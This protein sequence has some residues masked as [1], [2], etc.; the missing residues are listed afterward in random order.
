MYP[1]AVLFLW[2]CQADPAAP[3]APPLDLVLVTLDT[4]R[5]DRLGA[6]GD[7]LAKTPNLDGLAAR[8]ALFREAYTPVPLTLPA[9]ASLLTGLYPDR[10]GLRDNSGY[11][12]G[13]AVVTVTERLGAEGYHTGAFVGAYVLDAAWGLDAGFD[14]YQG[15]FHPEDVANATDPGDVQRPAREV[16][17]EALAWWTSTASPRFLWV[18]L[19]D[20]HAPYAP[21]VDW[22]GD[23]YRGEVFEV[24]RALRSLLQTVGTA[25]LV[26]VAGDH[27]ENLGDGGEL[28]HGLLLT[29]SALRVPLIVQP[30][31]GV[32]EAGTPPTARTV[33]PRP[34]AWAPVLDLAP[35]RL[36]LDAVPDA[37]RAAR[38]VDVPVS[39]VD[40]APTLLDYAGSSCPGCD[41]RSLRPAIEGQAFPDVPVYAETT[42]PL[43]HYGWS[44]AFAARDAT[45]WTLRTPN[46]RV[47]DPSADPW[48]LR[49]LSEAAPAA[50][51]ALLDAH[52]IGWEGAPG[53]TDAVAVQAL[54]ALGY[55]TSTV[56]PGA[57]PL[58]DAGERMALLHR[59]ARAEGRMAS[60]PAAAEA[61]LRAV[62][63]LE[64][65]LIDAWFSLGV[66][67]LAADDPEGALAAWREVSTRS[68]GHVQALNN[69]VIV[70]RGL[71]RDDEALG[72]IEAL[73]ALNPHDPRWYRLHVN[74]LGRLER[75]AGVQDAALRGLGVAPED[76]YLGYMLGLAR[77][78]L[79]DPAGALEALDGAER[80][81]SR[82]PDLALWQGKAHEA[83]GHVDEAVAAWHR[84]AQASPTDLRPVLAAGLLLASEERCGEALPFLFTAVERGVRDPEVLRTYEDCGGL[85]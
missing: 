67:R 25:P 70:L 34:A 13:D 52:A 85:R 3:E 20:A 61:E 48:S 8:S 72:V 55:V 58:P 50:L 33:E 2:G 51:G 84:Q 28:E 81:G 5:A 56:T 24:D 30:P 64:P 15:D 7:P 75:S 42:Y 38:V 29:R 65:G 26:V 31:G 46:E 60:S 68:P 79:D 21:S 69:Q 53:P 19:Y 59:I 78:Q 12:L 18:H 43:H 73:E 62:L 27:G 1:L 36:V 45:R 74:L 11:R 82:A 23:P 6:Y 66:L 22:T 63:A 40:V 41:G 17:R 54:A 47:F 76:P 37:P 39:L 71:A 16:T 4:V 57:G 77:Y 9:H 44:P 14:T 35:E 32:S 83:L 10:H 49:P 80:H